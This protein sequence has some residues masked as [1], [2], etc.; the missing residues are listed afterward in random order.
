MFFSFIFSFY[1]TAG[2]H[3]R[4][5]AFLGNESRPAVVPAVIGR[6][7][8]FGCKSATLLTRLTQATVL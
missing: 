6:R 3:F 7:A 4:E 5:R 2:K 8:W 1:Y